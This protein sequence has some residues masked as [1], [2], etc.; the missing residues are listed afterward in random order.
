VS[1]NEI[2]VRHS[3]VVKKSKIRFNEGLSNKNNQ[4]VM[5]RN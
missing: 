1:K 5:T 4:P 2:P 3:I